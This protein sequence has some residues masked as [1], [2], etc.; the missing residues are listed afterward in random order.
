MERRRRDPRR[1]GSTV[2]SSLLEFVRAG[3]GCVAIFKQR[4]LVVE[5]ADNPVQA[6][7]VASQQVK[8]LRT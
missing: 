3:P 6:C 4:N 8:Q 1:A 7:V 5:F 2:Q